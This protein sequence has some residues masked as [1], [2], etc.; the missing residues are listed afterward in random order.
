M[1]RIV[2]LA[3]VALSLGLLCGPATA[4][5]IYPLAFGMTPQDATAA[6]RA[7]LVQIK[8]RR[9][10]AI[11]FADVDSGIPSLWYPVGAHIYLQ[12]RRGHLTGWTIDRRER[13][14][15]LPF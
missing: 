1:T 12:F 4:N 3:A 10:S 13:K 2:R 11:Y 9:S 14:R 5:N 15:W 7:P 8:A 6:L